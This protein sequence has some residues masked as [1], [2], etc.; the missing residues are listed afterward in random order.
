MP[1]DGA[2]WFL[3]VMQH[4]DSSCVVMMT[5]YEAPWRDIMMHDDLSSAWLLMMDHDDSSYWL[6]MRNIKY[7]N[8]SSCIMMGHHD[9]AFR[10]QTDVW[11]GACM[12]FCVACMFLSH[13][14]RYRSKKL[15][16]FPVPMHDPI[17]YGDSIGDKTCDVDLSLIMEPCH[18]NPLTHPHTLNIVIPAR[19]GISCIL[20]SNFDALTNQAS[21]LRGI[22]RIY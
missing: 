6:M 12:S 5:R 14:E 16:H 15:W 21:L 22:S 10:S 1:H 17:F 13:L 20:H 9:P 19:G 3:I 8:G 18:V 4:D 11:I 7:H 2:T